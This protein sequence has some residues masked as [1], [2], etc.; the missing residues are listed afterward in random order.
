MR[1]LVW[2]FDGTLRK[3]GA[4]VR[5]IGECIEKS[6]AR[7]VGDSR[8]FS[9]TS[10][11][12]VPLAHAGYPLCGCE[13]LRRMVELFIPGFR[14]CISSRRWSKPRGFQSP[15]GDGPLRVRRFRFVAIV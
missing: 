5:C 9:P 8:Q 1:Y 15:R 11:I 2:D 3:N 13:D 6:K 7:L 4:M 10:S 12:W 14:A